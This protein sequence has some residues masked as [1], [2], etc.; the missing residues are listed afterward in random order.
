MG[1]QADSIQ[2]TIRG[3]PPAVDRALRR[4]AEA[5]QLSLNQVIVE[6]LALATGTAAQRADFSDLVGKW[7]D[8]P[9]FDDVIASQRKIDRKKWK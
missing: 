2:Y 1:K 8:D 9:G 3:V 7:T 6:E 5:R 4:K